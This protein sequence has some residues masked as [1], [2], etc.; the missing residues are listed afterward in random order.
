[1]SEVVFSSPE[2]TCQINKQI[3]KED[4]VRYDTYL[5]SYRFNYASHDKC[6]CYFLCEV[7]KDARDAKQDAGADAVSAERTLTEWGQ[8]PQCLIRP[9]QVS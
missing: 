1:M 5:Y 2:N 4:I 6:V 8:L 9:P 3:V 7:T